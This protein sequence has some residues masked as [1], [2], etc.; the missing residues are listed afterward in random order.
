MAQLDRRTVIKG[1][2]A[3]GA[4]LSAPSVARAT[5]PRTSV[6]VVDT[7]FLPSATTALEWEK[8]GAAVIDTRH[9]DLGNAWRRRIPDLL[10]RN[11]GGVAGITLWS[12][13]LI[14]QMFAREH[15]LV[16]ASPP[17]AVAPAVDA[18][19]HYWMLSAPD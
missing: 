4:V 9:D 13:M 16:L 3:A 2:L 14:C 19:L 7:R 12:D 15:G 17:R 6:F 5:A 1:T 10:A 11:G 18:G 8:L